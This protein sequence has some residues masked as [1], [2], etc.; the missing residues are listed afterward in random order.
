MTAILPIYIVIVYQEN[1]V[2]TQPVCILD[3]LSKTSDI[4]KGGVIF[5]Q[6]ERPEARIVHNV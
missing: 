4:N 5:Y 3:D 6:K 1:Q 2:F